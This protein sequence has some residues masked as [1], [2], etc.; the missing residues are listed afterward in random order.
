MALP[1]VQERMGKLDI[2][3]VGSSSADFAKVISQEIQL[4]TQVAKENNIKAE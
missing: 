2:K 1:D 3:P 4:W